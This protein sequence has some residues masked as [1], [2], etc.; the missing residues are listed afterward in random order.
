ME[1]LRLQKYLAHAGIASRR[2]I[3]KM[4]EAGD[5]TVNGKKAKLGD[6]VTGSEK[7]TVK[8]K[9]IKKDAINKKRTLIAFHKPVGVECTMQK[10]EDAKTL[11]DY[12]FGPD[13]MYPI[14]RLDKASR[15][16]VL[17][18]NDGDLANKL[19]H[20]RY[21]HEKEYVVTIDQRVTPK[22]IDHLSKGALHIGGKNVQ[23]AI[24]EKRGANVFSIILKEGRNRQIRKMCGALNLTVVDLLR[25]RIATIVLGDLA[26]GKMRTIPNDT[27]KI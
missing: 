3:E 7:I 26:V 20:P 5:I 13:R 9:T 16:L 12:D 15:G 14:G 11:A 18:T 1:E 10:R 21:E 2:A 8:G 23:K 24:V 6:K 17:M 22:I 19:T 25:T 27:L 4:I